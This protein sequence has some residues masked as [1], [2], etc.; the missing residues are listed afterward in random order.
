V[1]WQ[2]YIG[3]GTAGYIYQVTPS[4]TLT[5]L[6]SFAS[7]TFNS[8]SNFV[9]IVQ[10]TDGNLYGA[11]TG[12][13]ANGYGS[14]YHLTPAGQYTTLYSFTKGIGAYPQSLIQASDGNLYVASEGV[15]FGN[16]GQISRVSTSGQYS[17]I[18]AMIGVSGTC[19]CIIIQGSDGEIYGTALNGGNGGG[20]TVFAIN[21]G[22]PKPAPQA[23]SFTPAA[24]PVG[25]QVR[26]WGYNLLKAAVSFNGVTATKVHNSGPNY[27]FATVPEGATTGPIIVTTPGGTS[28]TQSSFTVK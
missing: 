2:R 27:V 20:G 24:A 10:G 14:V 25:K 17:A 23:L 12:G 5:K 7:G 1:S 3:N 26:I 6:Y 4:G 21:A 15:N 22:L 11:T 9:P 18:H 8:Y 19:E 13:G 16:A 28:T